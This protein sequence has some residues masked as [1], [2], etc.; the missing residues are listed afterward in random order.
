M[1]KRENMITI[2]N[3][4]KKYGKGENELYAL[5]YVDLNIGKGNICVILG[6]SASGKSTLLNMLG[7]LDSLDEGT[8]MVDGV[9]ITKL[10]RKELM[11]YRRKKIG[12]VFQPYNLIAELGAGNTV[13][14][15]GSA[16]FSETVK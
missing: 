2:Q 3:P 6:P 5:N 10:G 9:D 15:G 12:V 4:V 14:N 1:D 7:G 13:K 11:E 8:I 16:H